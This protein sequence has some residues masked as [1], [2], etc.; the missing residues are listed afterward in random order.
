[1]PTNWMLQKVNVHLLQVF[2]K[3]SF[4]NVAL[5][6][7]S[8]KQ[9]GRNPSMLHWLSVSVVNLPEAFW[10]WRRPGWGYY[11]S[12][13][14]HNKHNITNA[15]FPFWACS[16]L[17]FLKKQTK[18]A[19]LSFSFLPVF[20]LQWNVSTDLRTDR[21]TWLPQFRIFFKLPVGIHANSL[22]RRQPCSQVS[23]IDWILVTD[24]FLLLIELLRHQEVNIERWYSQR[25]TLG[26]APVWI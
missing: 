18:R 8:S 4:C 21:E 24:G 12:S 25:K 3:T 20:V 17:Y 16:I 1:M 10:R 5:Q 13:V 15:L 2:S 22:G 14:L 11:R 26:F 19:A 9:G 6:R 7:C 23:L